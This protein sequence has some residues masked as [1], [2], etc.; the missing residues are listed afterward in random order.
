MVYSP[1]LFNQYGGQQTGGLFGSMSSYED[2]QRQA[3]LQK[4]SSATTPQVLT[5]DSL[6]Y[7]ADDDFLEDI[8]EFL[9]NPQQWK[10]QVNN[11]DMSIS[12]V[13]PTGETFGDSN[14]D[15]FASYLGYGQEPVYET[16]TAQTV[17]WPTQDRVK[18]FY[19]QWGPSAMYITP[20]E[21]KQLVQQQFPEYDLTTP[22]NYA[23]FQKAIDYIYKYGDI[24]EEILSQPQAQP[25]AG[26]QVGLPDKQRVQQFYDTMGQAAMYITAEEFQQLTQ[27][28]FPEYDLSSTENYNAFQQLLDDIYYMPE[29]EDV[30]G[31]IKVL[32]P[33][34]KVTNFEEAMTD[35]YSAFESNPEEFIA[36]LA[37]ATQIM[38]GKDY[39]DI[40]DLSS[41][42]PYQDIKAL[43][44]TINSAKVIMRA[45]GF[46]TLEIEQ[47]LEYGQGLQ[48]Y[49]QYTQARELLYQEILKAFDD[50]NITL[51]PEAIDVFI[52]R[53]TVLTNIIQDA[54]IPWSQEMENVIR[55]LR[56]ELDDTKVWEVFYGKY[57]PGLFE[58][59]YDVLR[60]GAGDLNKV[61]GSS[62]KWAGQA[63]PGLESAGQFWID[64]TQEELEREGLQFNLNRG[65]GWD[66]VRM[67]PTE[68]FLIGTAVFTGGAGGGLL[69]SGVGKIAGVTGLTA[70]RGAATIGKFGTYLLKATGM[71]TV[72]R[73]LESWMEAGGTYEQALAMGWS[74]KEASDAAWKVFNENI[75]LIG[76]DAAQF[77]TAMLNFVKLP[78]AIPRLLEKGIVRYS[79]KG[80]GGL[81]VIVTEGGEEYYQHIR[82]S[83]VLGED[84]SLWA[85]KHNLSDEDILHVT[86]LGMM[87]GAAF[88][89]GAHVISVARTVV[90][91]L[92]SDIQ[93]EVQKK[94]ADGIRGGMTEYQAMIQALD[95]V[96]DNPEVQK[97]IDGAVQANEA[98]FQASE[99]ETDSSAR[100]Q[101][102]ADALNEKI[103]SSGLNNFESID[104]ESLMIQR[105]AGG[106][107]N[108]LE[109]AGN[110]AN[111]TSDNIYEVIDS[112]ATGKTDF[113]YLRETDFASKEEFV[114]TIKSIDEYQ[115]GLTVQY[116][117]DGAVI[118]KAG[119]ETETTPSLE[120]QQ[121]V[122]MRLGKEGRLVARHSETKMSPETGEDTVYTT[123][124]RLIKSPENAGAEWMGNKY[125]IIR[126]FSKGGI[127]VSRDL[128]ETAMTPDKAIGAI[129]YESNYKKA[130]KFGIARTKYE[131]YEKQLADKEQTRIEEENREA[132]ERSKYKATLEKLG[133]TKNTKKID[134]TFLSPQTGQNITVPGYDVGNGIGVAIHGEGKYKSYTVTHL[135]TGLAMGHDWKALKEAIALAK[136]AAEITDWSK[137][138]TQQ[139][140]PRDIMDKAADLVRGFTQGRL[141]VE[142]AEQ[143][144]VPTETVTEEAVQ[145]EGIEEAEPTL[146]YAEANEQIQNIVNYYRQE[147]ADIQEV[148]NRLGKYVQESL[149]VSERGKLLTQ[150]KNVKNDEQLKDAMDKVNEVAETYWHKVLT[151][152]IKRELVKTKAKTQAG[153]PVG[154]FTP[155]TQELLDHIRTHLKD[156]REEVRAKITEN[157]SAVDAGKLDRETAI[158]AH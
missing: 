151:S 155:E 75:K 17:S 127:E 69:A 96:S 109:Q 68:I 58:Q 28:Q 42:T 88:A 97:I 112:V 18:Q 23:D 10:Y 12:Y 49:E 129:P 37:K 51:A 1:S 126:V 125:G 6:K 70:V 14:W 111:I 147:K 92:P 100:A 107:Y 114:E 94:I 141:V 83:Q 105:T 93:V 102:L 131:S 150:I 132:E 61:I 48:A 77:L 5:Y 19:D 138:N 44:K 13:S 65:Y 71:A 64:V 36:D 115:Q 47:L 90:N 104:T 144:Q 148:K 31:A 156:N 130:E 137:Y 135:N 4:L 152:K 146:T 153:Y 106:V 66:F 40:I 62:L 25:Q 143:P 3:L 67:L 157:I 79:L 113:A 7:I 99:I 46:S 76:L 15:E 95:S 57:D 87:G 39:S 84:I 120:A 29:T 121:G 74:K 140:I 26:G 82:Q 24:T 158:Q 32:Y 27:Q 134:I 124:Y 9:P 81:G 122:E 11:Q 73:G 53:P 52:K 35:I 43:D 86:I 20:D 41:P 119:F 21:F 30:A 101:Q 16:T 55:A 45:L 118:S 108:V 98:A 145:A 139:E 63:I 22:E 80:I 2:M 103:K 33:D 116:T 154:K 149:P 133:T 123:E 78:G 142:Q 59:V 54:N 110:I 117:D 89:G 34:I 91:N 38:P 72:S 50:S 85:V 8:A 56:P 128:L 60:Q 136:S